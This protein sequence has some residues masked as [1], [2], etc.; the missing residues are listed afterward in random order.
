MFQKFSRVVQSLHAITTLYKYNFKITLN[1][2]VKFLV[3]KIVNE[4]NPIKIVS[5]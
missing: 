4:L 3:C 5:F 2:K 1:F